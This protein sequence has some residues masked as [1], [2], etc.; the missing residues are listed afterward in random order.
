MFN[1]LSKAHPTSQVLMLM[2]ASS[3]SYKPIEP[4]EYLIL[5]DAVDLMAD[6]LHKMKLSVR[7]GAVDRAHELLDHN[8]IN[9][10]VR[11][12]LPDLYRARR[13]EYTFAIR[14]DK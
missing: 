6:A 2:N 3:A 13:D 10:S 11:S 14:I 5:H 12:S 4:E 7:S 9:C 8:R 1:V